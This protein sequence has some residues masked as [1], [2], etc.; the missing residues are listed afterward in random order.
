TMALPGIGPRVIASGRMPRYVLTH[1]NVG[2]PFTPAEVEG[3]VD[4]F[5]APERADAAH[6]LYRYYQSTFPGLLRGRWR[7]RR[8]DVPTLLLLAGRD[9]YIPTTLAP[10][11][12]DHS[13]E[14]TVEVVPE[15]GH[16]IVNE[17][18]GL[19][20]DRALTFFDA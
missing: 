18:P 14:M 3:F 19:L 11:Y 6:R 4:G 17:R 20:L 1:G 13:S 10:G 5:R 9:R 15:T 16:F 8:I 2:T 12:E 7:D